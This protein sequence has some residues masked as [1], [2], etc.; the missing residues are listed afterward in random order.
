MAAKGSLCKIETLDKIMKI[1][2]D[3]F[4]TNNGKELRI[5]CVENG[6]FVQL[7]LTL[8]AVKQ[9]ILNENNSINFTSSDT[10]ILT[11]DTPDLSSLEPTEEEKENLKKLMAKLF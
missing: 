4:L 3:S 5:N 6:E 7:K 8:T 11:P 2:P 1:F 10:N 9:P